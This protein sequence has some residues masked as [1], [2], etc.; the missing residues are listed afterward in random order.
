VV[1]AFEEGDPDRPII[2]GSVYN[3]ANMPPLELPDEK[4]RAG[5]KSCIFQGDPAVNFN[6]IVFHDNPGEEY[7]QV[8]SEKYQMTNTETDQYQFTP[9]KTYEFYGSF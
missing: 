7:V 8:H 4:M 2:V 9:H 3:A 1:V 6:A 5:V